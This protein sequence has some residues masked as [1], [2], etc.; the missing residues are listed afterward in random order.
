MII[1][2]TDISILKEFCKLN[3]KIVPLWSLMQKIFPEGKQKEYM[4]IRKKIERMSR[5]GLFF[6]DEDEDNHYELDQDNVKLKKIKFPN[7]K[8]SAILLK[9]CGKWE[10]FEL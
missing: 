1:D 4:R 7:G 8:K 9:S 6:I 2:S 5:D 10:I 3:G